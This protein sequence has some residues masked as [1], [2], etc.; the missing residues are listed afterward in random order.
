MLLLI[1]AVHHLPLSAVSLPPLGSV[2]TQFLLHLPVGVQPRGWTA[3]AA[4]LHVSQQLAAA[5]PL[6][7]LHCWQNQLSLDQAQPAKHRSLA[8]QRSEL[9]L[10]AAARLLRPS[11]SGVPLLAPLWL[12]LQPNLRA[13]FLQRA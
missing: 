9:L 10:F 1:V 6:S 5:P 8:S 13:P 12:Q 11:T 3:P 2:L 7:R 4:T